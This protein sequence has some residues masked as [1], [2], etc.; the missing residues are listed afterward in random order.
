MNTLADRE[1]QANI[2]DE[3][4]KRIAKAFARFYEEELCT[5]CFGNGYFWVQ[6][7]AVFDLPGLK[8]QRTL[9]LCKEC[10]GTG[11]SQD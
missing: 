6:K 8:N 1:L 11:K 7:E 5:Y 10:L 3:R 9:E 2:C 4:E